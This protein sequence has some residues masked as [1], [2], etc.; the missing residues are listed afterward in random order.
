[1][2]LIADKADAEAMIVIGIAPLHSEAR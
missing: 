1:M 2:I